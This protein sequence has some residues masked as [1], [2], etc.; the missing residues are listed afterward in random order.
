MRRSVDVKKRL[1]FRSLEHWYRYDRWQRWDHL[2]DLS[3]DLLMLIT[4]LKQ[5]MILNGHSEVENG[6]QITCRSLPAQLFFLRPFEP[7]QS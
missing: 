4:P 5:I 6:E 7:Q 1:T 2:I 3:L